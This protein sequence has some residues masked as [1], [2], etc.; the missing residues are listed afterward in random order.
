MRQFGSIGLAIL[1]L[2][3]LPPAGRADDGSSEPPAP[4]TTV[5]VGPQS[6]EFIV[7]FDRPVNHT[8]SSLAIMRDG[9]VIQVLNSRLESAPNVLFARIPTPSA[10]LYVL[11]WMFCPEGTNDRFNGEISFK[12]D[13]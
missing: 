12:V 6:T 13:R 3:C 7:R 11:R 8:L 4:K 1:G 9:K 10:G 2:I 5:V